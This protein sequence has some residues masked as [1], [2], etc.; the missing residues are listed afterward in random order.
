MAG[1]QL[2]RSIL[3]RKERDELQAIASAMSLKPA[4]PLEEGRHHRPDP[5]GDRRRR[6]TAPNGNGERRPMATRRSTRSP[7][8]PSVARRRRDRHRRREPTAADGR[9]RLPSAA[10]RARPGDVGRRRRSASEPQ[11][12]ARDESVGDIDGSPSTADGDASSERVERRADAST[13]A[14]AATGGRSEHDQDEAGDD[15]SAHG[16]ASDADGNGTRR[17]ATSRVGRTAADSAGRPGPATAQRATTDRP[18]AA[19][20][21]GTAAAAA[22]VAASRERPERPGRPGPR[23][24]LAGRARPGQGAA[25]PARRGLRL[26]A[27]ERLPRR[28]RKDVYVSVSQARRF[29]LRKGDAIEGACRPAGAEREVPGADPHRHDRRADA[30]RGPRA[31]PLRG[32]HAAVPRRAAPP[33][34][35][36]R[37]AEHHGADRRPHLADRQGPAR[38]DRLAAEGRQDDDHE[39]DR[40]LDRG[41]TTPRSTSSC[42]SSTSGPKRSP[43]C[44]AR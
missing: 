19:E 35:G 26:P 12:R 42:C 24:A 9:A 5:A 36:R 4:G 17:T 20:R 18:A 14:V 15:A 43:T 31:S 41:A 33:R 25:R 23:G 40:P 2:E 6:P 38:D 32:P 11:R 10:P 27:D 1:E 30:R 16:P 13:A 22:V 8:E 37:P 3:E 7:S 44:A 28:A 29:A 21:P 34:A 39:A